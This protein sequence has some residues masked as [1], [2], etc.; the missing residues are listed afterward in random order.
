MG[1]EIPGKKVVE[2]FHFDPKRCKIEVDDRGNLHVTQE[3]AAHS[4]TAAP[5]FWK[6]VAG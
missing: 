4:F 6:E 2:M 3:G 5:T 1:E